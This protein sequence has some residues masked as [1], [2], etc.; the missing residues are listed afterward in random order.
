MIRYLHFVTHA[1]VEIDP[2]RPV[3]DWPLSSRGRARH[4][5]GAQKAYAGRISSLYCS[6]ER[7]ARDGTDILST[8]LGCPVTTMRA[9]HEND[10]SAT[11]FLPKTEFEATA[12]AF[13]AHPDTSIRGWET[14]RDAQRRIVAAVTRI[15][16]TDQTSGDIGILS[17]GGV[18]ALMLCHA[19]G[20]PISRERDQPGGAGGNVFTLRLP[21]LHLVGGWRDLEDEWTE[22]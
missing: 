19:M 1:D 12:D 2:D 6:D 7:K 14:A 17:H 11:G 13:F 8:A 3:P 21:G 4:A 5:S 22:E 9:L 15:A 20:V 10:R 16:T 18:G